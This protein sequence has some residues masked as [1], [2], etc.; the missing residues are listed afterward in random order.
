M[1]RISFLFRFFN[2]QGLKTYISF[3]WSYLKE[4]KL[5]IWSLVF[6]ILIFTLAG[7]LFPITVGWAVDYGIKGQDI[8]YIYWCGFFLSLCGLT[9]AVMFFKISYGFR[10]IGQNVLYKIR[11]DLVEY[12]QKIEV[13]YF[14]KTSS[15]K[16]VTQISN[17]TRSLGELFSAGFSG[18]LICF[19]EIISIVIAL[20]I[21]SWPMALAVMV[22]VP[23][24][25]WCIVILT[26]KIRQQFMLIKAKLSSINAYS[27]ESFNGIQVLQLYNKEAVTL[28]HFQQEAL[29]YRDLSIRGVHFYALL[30]PLIEFFQFFS[31]VI[32]L[33]LGLYLSNEDLISIGQITA[34]ILLLQSFFDPL[35]TILEKYQQVQNGIASSQRVIDLFKEK[36]E[37]LKASPKV[38]TTKAVEDLQKEVAIECKNLEFWYKE[39]SKK[40]LK[41]ISLTI[42]PQS[43]NALVGHTGSGKTTLASLFQGFYKPS[44]G[45]LLI[46]GKDIQ[47]YSVE[48]LRKKVLVVRQEEFI[49]KGT[50]FSN[51]ILG[52]LQAS[53]EKVLEAIT[54]M[55]LDL[56]L[57]HPVDQMGSNLSAGERQLIALSRV[58][59]FNP[60]IIILDEATSHIDKAS[61]N[62]VLMAMNKI[63]KGKT[64]IVIAHRLATVLSSHQIFVLD[65]GELVEQGHPKELLLD[66]ENSRLYEFYNQLL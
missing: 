39:P 56:P 20:F 46:Y 24:I 53:Q 51:V 62:K 55:G 8:E 25:L 26:Q 35:R 19:I 37:T 31:I 27:A 14:D 18:A 1:N 33:S 13:S 3:M 6:F 28:N 52:N 22:I 36:H 41:K 23:P 57:E 17:D 45:E 58:V 5:K 34:F 63:L 38:I 43:Q 21:L 47:S 42:S 44:G 7:R 11:Q 48:D 29:D 30:W 10:T 4:Y 15:G 16:T 49:F 2:D 54:Q 9:S 64:S 59:L 32:S 65:Q 40:A 60:D 50:V 66:R 12:V 61:E